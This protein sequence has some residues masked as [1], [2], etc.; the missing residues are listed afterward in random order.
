MFSHLGSETTSLHLIS[1]TITLSGTCCWTNLDVLEGSL[2]RHVMCVHL[3]S[4]AFHWV[5]VA[6]KFFLS[7]FKELNELMALSR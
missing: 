1:R 2:A 6:F 7:K 4:S 5:P 3:I